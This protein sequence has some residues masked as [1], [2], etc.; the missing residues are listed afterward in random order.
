MAILPTQMKMVYQIGQA[1]GVALD[2]GHIKEFLVA[3]GVGL[4]SQV[5]EAY[6]TRLA[7]GVLGRVFGGVGRAI[8]GPL[9]GAA[10][11]FATTY[12]LGHVAEQYYAG[13]RTMSSEQLRAAFDA[14]ISEAKELQ[15]TYAPQIQACS[16]NLR[17]QNLLSR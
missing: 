4:S 16:R 14:V 2:R 13:G 17:L 3:A 12:A 6:A 7:K 1:H 11:S 15:A 5:V 9:T 8:A 10:M